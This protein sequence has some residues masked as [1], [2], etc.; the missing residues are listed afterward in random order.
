MQRRRPP[1]GAASEVPVLAVA[2]LGLMPENEHRRPSTLRAP[3]LKPPEGNGTLLWLRPGRSGSAA[4]G[5]SGT[6]TCRIG[7]SDPAG[8]SPTGSRLSRLGRARSRTG[9]IVPERHPGQRRIVKTR[10]GLA[11]RI[12]APRG[13]SLTT[14]GDSRAGCLFNPEQ[15][16]DVFSQEEWTIGPPVSAEVSGGRHAGMPAHLVQFVVRPAAY[17]FE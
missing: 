14:S 7:R 8:I 12:S 16:G 6:C 5:S 1:R 11:I 3:G 13:V 15:R 4:R 17:L 10:A 9:R 2:R